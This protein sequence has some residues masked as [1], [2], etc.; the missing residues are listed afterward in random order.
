MKTEIITEKL[1]HAAKLIKDGE[2]V[3]VPTE[4]V[5]GLAGNGLDATAVEKIYGGKAA[6]AYGR[7]EERHGKIL[8]GGSQAGKAPCR[9]VL[10]GAADYRAEG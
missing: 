6:L 2:L 5:Y 7:G 9:K 8:R 10:A 3:A 4:T 1:S